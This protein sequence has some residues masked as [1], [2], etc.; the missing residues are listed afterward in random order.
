MKPDIIITWPKS[1][2]YPLW[3][4][5]IHKQRERFSKVIVIWMETNTGENYI[6][7]IQKEMAE[8]NIEFYKS[9]PLSA[10]ADW[11][12]VAVNLGLEHS[13]NEWVWFTEQ[14]FIPIDN[15]WSWVENL[16]TNKL[17]VIGAYQE[18]RL[19]PCCIFAK[20]SVINKTKKNFAVIPNQ[21]DHFAQFQRDLDTLKIEVGHIPAFTYEHLN[22]LSQNMTLISNGQEPNYQKER[23]NQ[24]IQDCLSININLDE[25]FKTLCIKYL[26]TFTTLVY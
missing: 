8:D 22:G 1:C 7:F 9:P 3:R 16:I 17:E 4:S 26:Q 21:A 25:R 24:Y 14:D 5:F 18:E 12:D 6:D 2:D 15:L 13:T 23:F 10:A 11:R 20:R 19:H